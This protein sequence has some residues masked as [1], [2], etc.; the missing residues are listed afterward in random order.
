[1]VDFDSA[2]FVLILQTLHIAVVLFGPC[3]KLLTPKVMTE[4]PSYKCTCQ[5]GVVTAVIYGFTHQICIK[6]GNEIQI[7]RYLLNVPKKYKIK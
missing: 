2:F 3:V 5:G 6:G 1:M 7:F 4:H